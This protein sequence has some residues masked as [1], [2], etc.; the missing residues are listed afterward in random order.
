M[1]WLDDEQVLGICGYVL[2]A[3]RVHRIIIMLYACKC[4]HNCKFTLCKTML[5]FVGKKTKKETEQDESED[6]QGEDFHVPSVSPTSRC[7]TSSLTLLM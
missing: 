7:K 6:S 1:T 2:R 4:R 5:L 3:I